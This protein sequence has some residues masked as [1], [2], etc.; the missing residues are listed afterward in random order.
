MEQSTILDT[1]K[2]YALEFHRVLCSTRTYKKTISET[3]FLQRTEN[4]IKQCVNNIIENI[5]TIETVLKTLSIGL[6]YSLS[7]VVLMATWDSEL[8]GTHFF[9]KLATLFQQTPFKFEWQYDE[10]Q[11]KL[12]FSI[13]SVAW[14][15][16]CKDLN[17]VDLYINPITY[18]QIDPIV[19]NYLEQQGWKFY[20]PFTG[21]QTG[22]LLMFP[23]EATNKLREYL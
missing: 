20:E 21:D 6:L 23:I 16:P 12:M 1:L 10:E 7:D 8:G 14:F 2:D 3:E 11:K 9:D 22:M 5:E 4:Y 17:S 18:S 15:V 13:D 19:F